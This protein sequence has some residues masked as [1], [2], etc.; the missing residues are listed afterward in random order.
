MVTLLNGEDHGEH[1]E[2][3]CQKIYVKDWEKYKKSLGRII[4]PNFQLRFRTS[5][6]SDKNDILVS[7]LT[8]TAKAMTPRGDHRSQ[9]A[10][11]RVCS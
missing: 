9:F 4:T 2:A 5:S 11:T 10:K 1:P 7:M 3:S 6:V 8:N